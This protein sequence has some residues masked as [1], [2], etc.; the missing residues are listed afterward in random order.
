MLKADEYRIPAYA[1]L[2]LRA[3]IQSADGS[4]KA[5]VFGRN[6][7]NKTYATTIFSGSD[8]LY[9]YTGRPATYGVSLTVRYGN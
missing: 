3:G 2:D 8:V 7:G 6:V 5:S 4:W 9:R 1:L